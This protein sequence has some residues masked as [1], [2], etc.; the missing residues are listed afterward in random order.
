MTPEQL[1]GRMCSTYAFDVSSRLCWMALG[2]VA[3]VLLVVVPTAS[4]AGDQGQ[5]VVWSYSADC[6]G[7]LVETF[8]GAVT[9]CRP[10]PSESGQGVY[11]VSADGSIVGFG[12]QGQGDTGPVVLLRSDGQRVVLDSSPYD[13][14]AAISPDGSKVVF[15]RY[16]PP[17]NPIDGATDLFVINSDGSDLKQVASGNGINVLRVPTFSPDGS[18]I[19]YACDPSLAVPD[20]QDTNACG[21]L[22]DGTSRIQ[23]VILMKADGSDKRAI[24]IGGVNSLSWSPDGKWIAT[25]GSAPCT[26]PGGNTVNSQVYVYH[27]DGSDLF[28]RDDR[29]RRVTHETDI[30]GAVL[31]QFSADGTQIVYLRTIDDHGSQGNFAFIVNRD[32]TDRHELNL[33]PEGNLWGEVVPAS[34]GEGPPPPVNAM[35]LTVP[36]VQK[37]SYHAAKRRLQRAHLRVGEI[38]RTFSARIRPGHVIAQFPRA[39]AHAHRSHKQGPRV[40]LVLSR[41]SHH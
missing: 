41:G 12:E 40:N 2:L 37:L 34:K 19:A 15:G 32:G 31:P 28:N 20:W 38:R 23:A 5:I 27:T 14:D 21:P 22:P 17:Y 6:S 8:G 18:A 3:A 4:S 9:G 30:P 13:F 39:G 16:E 33:S 26:C 36:A 1:V 7:Y 11:S 29:N 24:L 25:D 35:R 10:V